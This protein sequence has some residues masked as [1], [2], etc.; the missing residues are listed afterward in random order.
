MS[1]RK[2]PGFIR[3]RSR[4]RFFTSEGVQ[5]AV[6]HRNSLFTFLVLV[7]VV[8]SGCGPANSYQAPPPPDVQVALPLQQPVT[9]YVEQT[10]T[11]Q[12]SAR[13]ELRA[14]VNGF[15]Q[16]RKFEDGDLVKAGQL[17]FVIDEEPFRVKLQYALAKER[18]ASA[19]LQKAKQSKAREIARAQVELRQ[20]EVQ[21]ATKN[22]SRHSDLLAQKATAQQEFDQ[23]AAAL[24]VADAQLLATQAEL[25]Q[26]TVN[27]DANIL[28]AEAALELAKSEVRTAEL[29]LGYCRVTAPIS[30]RIDR[31]A[32]DIGN[33]ITADSS[34]PLAAIVKTDPIYA[35]AAI[36]ENELLRIQSRYMGGGKE[37]SIPVM[38]AIG[39]DRTFTMTGKVD[40]ISPTVQTGTGTVQVRGVFENAGVLPG[41]F[42]RLRIPSEEHADAILVSERSLAYDQTG[43]YVYVVNADD[44]VERRLVIPGDLLDSHR[45]V[46]GELTAGDRVV[47]D[48]LLKVRPGMKVNPKLAGKAERPPTAPSVTTRRVL[49]EQETDAVAA[50]S[51]N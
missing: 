8:E 14:R 28:G 35:Y 1:V 30:G 2:Y 43:A 3:S 34:T 13:V 51:T 16:E 31:R 22:H 7:T 45:V 12:A 44:T 4:F 25:E 29:D 32:F 18:E 50:S 9:S 10:G 20:S 21:L 15:L 48:G 46:K 17:L 24:Q 5:R 6:V 23:V 36:N 37:Q 33:Y 49:P 47:V 27:F 41:M 38:M 11:A 39:E 19:N 42:I 40:Y 26:A